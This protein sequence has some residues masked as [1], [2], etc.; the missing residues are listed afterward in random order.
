MS[1]HDSSSEVI[2]K[3]EKDETIKMLT[4]LETKKLIPKN[5]RKKT[6]SN[7]KQRKSTNSKFETSK[8]KITQREKQTTENN[9]TELK[10]M[11]PTIT[12]YNWNAFERNINLMKVDEITKKLNFCLAKMHGYETYGTHF[13]SLHFLRS[14][15]VEALINRKWNNL[16][17]LIIM[18]SREYSDPLFVRFIR[19]LCHLLKKYHPRIRGTEIENQMDMIAEKYKYNC[20]NKT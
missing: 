1:A 16:L 11:L 3:L 18:L 13:T 17:R 6:K 7:C 8:S 14:A 2:I 4:K 5:T 20:R 10:F 9:D 12:A 15:I 19:Q